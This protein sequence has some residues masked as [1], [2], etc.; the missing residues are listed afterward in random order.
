[1]FHTLRQFVD[2]R[3]NMM[4]TMLAPEDILSKKDMDANNLHTLVNFFVGTEWMGNKLCGVQSI[5]FSCVSWHR[6][7]STSIGPA[8]FA[9][10][11]LQVTICWGVEWSFGK[12]DQIFIF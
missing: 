3:G 12:D 2:L 10:E 7:A 5:W 9:A 4:D 8:V 11:A 6:R 1:M